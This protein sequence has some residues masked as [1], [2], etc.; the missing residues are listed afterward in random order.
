MYRFGAVLITANDQKPLGVV[1]KTDLV[2]AYKHGLSSDN[3][4]A[5]IMGMTGPRLPLR[6]IPGRGY[7][8]D[9]LR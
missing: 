2:L 1:S 8:A 6:R 7:S 5:E 4:A 9:D 3:S